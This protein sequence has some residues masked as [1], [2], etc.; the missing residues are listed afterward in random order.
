MAYSNFTCGIFFHCLLFI[1][2]YP[3]RY[4]LCATPIEN[5]CLPWHAL[6]FT[7]FNLSHGSVPCWMEPSHL[8]LLICFPFPCPCVCAITEAIT[9]IVGF[10]HPFRPWDTFELFATVPW[11]VVFFPQYYLF[12]N[13]HVLKL[14]LLS[15]LFHYVKVSS[16][17]LDYLYFTVEMGLFHALIYFVFL[18]VICT[19]QVFAFHF[20]GYLSN[21]FL[22]RW[23]ITC[24]F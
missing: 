13:V 16:T 18:N 22:C 20:I 19:T 8:L 7:Y 17:C 4:A 2:V 1:L 9:T 10:I 3:V 23:H 6:G 14:P 11:N 12:H 5:S 24:S 21:Q 15:W